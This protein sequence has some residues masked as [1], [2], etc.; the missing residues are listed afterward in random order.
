MITKPLQFSRE[1]RA[2]MRKVTWPGLKETRQLTIAVFVLV[3]V[4]SL[5]LLLMDSISSYIVNLL[6]SGF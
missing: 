5:F 1:V 4:V 3:V 6:I 2:E